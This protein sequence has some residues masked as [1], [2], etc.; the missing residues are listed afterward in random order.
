MKHDRLLVLLVVSTTRSHQIL[1]PDETYGAVL[2]LLTGFAFLG[3]L[4]A[5]AAFESIVSLTEVIPDTNGALHAPIP[6]KQGAGSGLAMKM[7]TI[8][9]K[10]TPHRIL[11]EGEPAMM[12]RCIGTA[13]GRVCYRSAQ[14]AT[15]QSE[16]SIPSS[17]CVRYRFINR[18]ARQPATPPAV[19]PGLIDDRLRA[20][21]RSVPSA[22]P[23]TSGVAGFGYQ[24]ALSLEENGANIHATQYSSLLARSSG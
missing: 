13:R 2:C 10:Y 24:L 14:Q 3:V 22:Y 16:P 1:R 12:Q 5:S 19:A 4:L 7:G 6:G 8:F 11:A 21:A 17:A 23:S 15:G 9:R 18:R 20:E